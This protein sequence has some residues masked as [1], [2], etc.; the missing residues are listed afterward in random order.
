MKPKKFESAFFW[1]LGIHEEHLGKFVISPNP[2]M[3][4]AQKR[5]TNLQKKLSY[6]KSLIN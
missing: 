3:I 5:R 1:G 2:M 6:E 4:R